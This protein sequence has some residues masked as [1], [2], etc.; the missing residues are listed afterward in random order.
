[1]IAVNM[2]GKMTGG[3]FTSLGT[4]LER[5]GFSTRIIIILLCFSL[6]CAGAGA[7]WSGLRARYLGLKSLTG[8]FV[9]TVEPSDGSD[10]MVFKGRFYFALPNRFRL[11]VREPVQQV[12]V[13]SDSLVVFYLPEEKRAV[14]QQRSQPVPMLAFVQPLL[15]TTSV[16]TEEQTDDGRVVLVFADSEWTMFRELRIEPD[17]TGTRV[18]AFS[19]VDEWGNRCRFVLAEQRWNVSIPAKMFKFVPPAGTVVEYQ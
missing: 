5:V 11:E 19:F 14:F 8:S 4:G 6:A 2:P 7:R 3:E 12:I 10:P 17:R 16:V 1:M 9:Q 15:D 13:G 18:D